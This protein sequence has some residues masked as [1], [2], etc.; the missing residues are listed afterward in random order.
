MPK[1]AS[2]IRL[3]DDLMQAAA[4]TAERFHRSTAEQIE[5]WADIGRRVS[6][7]LDP[8]DM[9]S[10]AAGL[11][12]VRV[13]PVAAAPLDP[14]AVFLSLERER[15]QGTLSA[16]V[17]GSPVR[18]QASRTH[19]GCLERTDADGQVAVGRFDGGRF[20]VATETGS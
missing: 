2:P 4:L 13:E 8:D 18:Y 19:P 14:D 7:L 10:V 11:A 5:Y 6:H 9:L 16:A 3:Q 15:A 17:T 12:R 20:V 1:S